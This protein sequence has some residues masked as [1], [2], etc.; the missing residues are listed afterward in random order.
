VAPYE[1]S[2]I[3]V[4]PKAVWVALDHAGEDISTFPGGLVEWN[5]VTHGVVRYPIEFVVTQIAHDGDSL[6][7]T[8][9][10][11]YA[12][13]KNG[14]IRRFRVQADA[15]GR[16]ETTAIDRFPPPPSTHHR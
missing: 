3:L 10:G 1:V 13:L 16:I 9:R 4:D 5:R 8:T 15:N 14:V 6:R 11:G 7:L 12:L 2:A